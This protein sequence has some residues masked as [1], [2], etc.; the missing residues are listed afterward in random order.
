[1]RNDVCFKLA[2]AK[3]QRK[4]ELAKLKRQALETGGAI[5]EASLKREEDGGL[6]SDTQGKVIFLPFPLVTNS[7]DAKVRA[8]TKMVDILYNSLRQ[9]IKDATSLNL[10]IDMQNPRQALR[11]G[12]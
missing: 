2:E 4:E 8:K 5:R 11:T 3:R 6:L 9:A 7:G 1:M 12:A 10:R